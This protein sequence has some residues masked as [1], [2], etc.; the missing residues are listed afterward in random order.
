MLNQ[1]LKRL[2]EE[3]IELKKRSFSYY[4]NYNKGKNITLMILLPF[5]ILF[6]AIFF[7]FFKEVYLP[8]YLVTYNN[9]I[10]YASFLLTAFFCLFFSIYQAYLRYYCFYHSLVLFDFKT[11]KYK[12]YSE[13]CS[14]LSDKKEKALRLYKMLNNEK[15]SKWVFYVMFLS[16]Q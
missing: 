8:D 6:V 4:F 9:F 1:E 3:Y 13:Y 15:E 14:A 11:P 2:N 10:V 16:Y 12:N 7:K 5:L